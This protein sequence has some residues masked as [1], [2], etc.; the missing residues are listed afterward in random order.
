MEIGTPD[1]KP[2][3]NGRKSHSIYAP[4]LVW[5]SRD[6]SL[7]SAVIICM[8]MIAPPTG[9]L[10]LGHIM[11]IL[12]AS[13]TM[14]TLCCT[15]M[16]PVYVKNTA[17]NKTANLTRMDRYSRIL[18]GNMFAKSVIPICCQLFRAMPD[19]TKDIQD[20]RKIVNSSG[21]GIAAFRT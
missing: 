2:I 14:W 6:V 19:P 17:K 15:R 13:E 11:E 20:S 9:K 10:S 3:R 4:S 5:K 1:I 21:H 16:N 8:I 18:L 12:R 7:Y